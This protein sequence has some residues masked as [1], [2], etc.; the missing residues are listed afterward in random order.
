METNQAWF[1]RISRSA[2]LGEIQIREMPCGNPVENADYAVGFG[3]REEG[4]AFR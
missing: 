2:T 4:V 1:A 3:T